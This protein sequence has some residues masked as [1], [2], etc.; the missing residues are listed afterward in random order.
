MDIEKMFEGEGG[1][2]FVSHSHL[3]LKK[4]REVRNFLELNGMEPILF[5]LRSMEG[6]DEKK[7]KLLKSLIY[8][9]IDSR[10]FFLYLDSENSKKSKWVQDELRY[11]KETNPDK[12]VMLP[13]S[14]DVESVKERL[15]AL[16][17]RM[18]VFISCSRADRG[19]AER[20]KK[21]LIQRDFRVYTDEEA[22]SIGSGADY[23]Q[24]ITDAI[25]NVVE[26]G[27][28]IVL[29]TEQ[30]VQSS[31]VLVEME[32]AIKCGGRVLPI[33]VGDVDFT[34]ARMNF[35]NRYQ[36]FRLSADNDDEEIEKLVDCIKAVLKK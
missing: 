22:V 24:Q 20:F 2:V 26:E 7:A 19:L 10:E 8:D 1:Y 14:G 5:Y 25:K 15:K 23:V 34:A 11:V 18:R 29:L 33:I 4:V 17:R 9:E 3:D 27:S 12:V 36:C 6:S 35:L 16:I 28:M 13:L 30:S 32:Y 21:A 31:H